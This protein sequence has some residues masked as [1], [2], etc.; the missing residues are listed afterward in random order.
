MP[1]LALDLIN[2]QKIR[3]HQQEKTIME[4]QNANLI[5][6]KTTIGNYIAENE[7]LKAEVERWRNECG[8]QST[9]WSKHFE[10]IFET[11][12]E[13]IKAEAYK[14]CIEKL[15]DK[16]D[17]TELFCCGDLVRTEYTITNEEF[18]NIYNELVGE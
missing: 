1:K 14:E 3:I 8:H 10:S 13:T 9:L 4:I 7:S 11:A 15:K 18:D 2:W 17:K 16:F 12:K 5:D 6:F